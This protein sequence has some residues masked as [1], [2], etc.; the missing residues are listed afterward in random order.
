VSDGQ[1]ESPSSRNITPAKM[2]VTSNQ[3]PVLLSQI[4]PSKGHRRRPFGLTAATFKGV[5]RLRKFRTL[6]MSLA[7]RVTV[8]HPDEPPQFK[9]PHDSE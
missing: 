9:E 7:T 4:V 8:L 3:F 2:A 1:R 6:A 5:Q